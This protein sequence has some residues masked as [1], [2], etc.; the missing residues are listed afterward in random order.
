[1]A[2]AFATAPAGETRRNADGPSPAPKLRSASQAIGIDLHFAYDHL[3]REMKAWERQ[4]QSCCSLVSGSGAYRTAMFYVNATI[5]ELA[6]LK[7]RNPQAFVAV[8][9]GAFGAHYPLKNTNIGTAKC[10]FFDETGRLLLENDKNTYPNGT[11]KVLDNAGRNLRNQRRAITA[12]WTNARTG[13]VTMGF[14]LF[15]H[16]DRLNAA[17][18]VDP[19]GRSGL[20]GHLNLCWIFGPD[21]MEGSDGHPAGFQSIGEDGAENFS[22][23]NNVL[24]DQIKKEEGEWRPDGHDNASGNL[25]EGRQGETGT[26]QGTPHTPL[27]PGGGG[28]NDAAAADAGGPAPDTATEAQKTLYEN[29]VSLWKTVLFLVYSPLLGTGRI[30]WAAQK[31]ASD[32]GF[33]E[34]WRQKGI[35]L[36]RE[37]LAALQNGEVGIHDALQIAQEAAKKQA[38]YLQKHP[39]IWITP[40][41]GFLDT[42]KPHGT[43]LSAARQF[44]GSKPLALSPSHDTLPCARTRIDHLWQRLLRYGATT[45]KVW[46]FRRWCNQFGPDHVQ[47]C[48]DHLKMV[49]EK[50][51]LEQGC[52]PGREFDRRKGGASAYFAGL[53]NGLDTAEAVRKLQSAAIATAEMAEIQAFLAHVM[54]NQPAGGWPPDSPEAQYR[55]QLTAFVNSGDAVHGRAALKAE[56]YF[57]VAI[58]E[59]TAYQLRDFA[60]MM[61]INPLSHYPISTLPH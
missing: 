8:R 46:V 12:S 17:G 38:E 20:I 22:A 7:A 16:W 5:R 50:R 37:N 31:Q 9:S 13:Q 40:P 56:R 44:V 54:H 30:R 35:E 11:P 39:K 6:A 24:N 14:P 23:K 52:E 48:L 36:C 61:F 27:V 1:M 49:A 10:L 60:L 34:K 2:A 15:S 57:G 58:R 59:K 28:E 26:G 43:L 51:R 47:V 32:A 29:A 45:T 19:K 42:T 33:G 18:Q 21:W 55:Q 53:V 25:T 4:H 3:M 41:I